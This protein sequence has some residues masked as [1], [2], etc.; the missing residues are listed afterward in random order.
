M[1]TPELAHAAVKAHNEC[2]AAVEPVSDVALVLSHEDAWRL[3]DL[4]TGRAELIAAKEYEATQGLGGAP[5]Y[6]LARKIGGLL[7]DPR[8]LPGRDR[9]EL[10]ALLGAVEAVNAKHVRYGHCVLCEAGPAPHHND[11]CPMAHFDFGG[12]PGLDG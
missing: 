7:G 12:S 6:T 9:F 1:D 8:A 4:V 5:W 2:P 10:L 11:G 3:Y